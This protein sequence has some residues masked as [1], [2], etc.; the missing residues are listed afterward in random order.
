[1]PP[2]GIALDAFAVVRANI[3]LSVAAQTFFPTNSGC[4]ASVTKTEQ[5]HN[6]TNTGRCIHFGYTS[7]GYIHWW[8]CH[9]NIYISRSWLGR[10]L[11][12]RRDR[13]LSGRAPVDIFLCVC[14][15]MFIMLFG[16][17]QMWNWKIRALI[18]QFPQGFK[19]S[20]LQSVREPCRHVAI[21]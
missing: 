11:G 10:S 9:L 5:Q 1:M 7:F 4:A 13:C 6:R 17:I 18:N 14:L 15:L 16:R 3:A 8:V 21:H 20:T 12:D 2:R 19:Y